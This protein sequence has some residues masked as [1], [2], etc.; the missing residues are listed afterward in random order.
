MHTQQKERGRGRERERERWEE[1]RE[2]SSPCLE[3]L[4]LGQR[5]T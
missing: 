3:P 2:L 5:L 1:G 4:P